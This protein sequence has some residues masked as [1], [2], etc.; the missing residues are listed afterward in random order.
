MRAHVSRNPIYTIATVHVESDGVFERAR[1]YAV[2]APFF[3]ENKPLRDQ[4]AVVN[5]V[6]GAMVIQTGCSP[7]SARVIRTR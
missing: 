5:T 3:N 2:T 7:C 4:P 1:R 6:A